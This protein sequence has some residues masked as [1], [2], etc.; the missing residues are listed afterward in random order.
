VTASEAVAAATTVTFQLKIDATG[1]TAQLADF[2]AGSFN[3]VT[4]T[5]PAGGTT[6][7]FDM[8]TITNDG[9]ELSEKYSVQA[10]VGSTVLTKQ[11]TILDGSVGAGQTFTLTTGVDTIPGLIGSNGNTVNS[12]ND[13]IIGVQSAGAT[14]TLTG[15]DFID[16]G[17]GVD[18]LRVISDVDG[19]AISLNAVSNAEIIEVRSASGGD[20]SIDTST[21]T[22]VTNLNITSATDTDSFTA[23]AADTTDIS[24]TGGATALTIKG[25]KNVTV[26]DATADKAITVSTAAAAG[27]AVGT[28]T[29]TDTKQGTGDIKVDGG[30]TVNVTAT[31]SSTDTDI[32]TGGDIIIGAFKPATGAVT[33]VQNLTST[34]VAV[35]SGAAVAVTGGSTVNVTVNATS[36]AKDDDSDDAITV[37]TVTV[38]GDGETT[39]VTAKQ[40]ATA[41][42]FTKPGTDEIVKTSVVTFGELKVGETVI[43]NG[44]TFTNNSDA[45]LTA[46]TVASIFANL[47]EDDLQAVG[48]T[49]AKGY[50]SN[51]FSTTDW[52]SGA[53]SGKTVT[54]T[55]DAFDTADLVL[56]GTAAAAATQVKSTNQADAVA[57]DKSTNAVAF[58]A[59]TV[60]E[61]DAAEAAITSVTLDGF[62]S[63]ALGVKAGGVT[64]KL[65]A[66]TTV[67][68]ANNTSDGEVNI[69]TKATALNLTV[70]D[71]IGGDG[72]VVNL[73]HN[74]NAT[75][76]GDKTVKTLTLNATG[77]ASAFELQARV[78]ETLTIDAAVALDLSAAGSDFDA[79]LVDVTVK[80]AGAVN[81][82]AIGTGTTLK[83]FNASANTGGVTATIDG[84]TANLDADFAEYVFSEGADV[85]A[86]ENVKVQEAIKLGGGNDKITLF[87]G[88]RLA[89]VT[90][91][92]DGGTGTN[93]LVLAADDA[94]ALSADDGFNGKIANFQ[95][96]S[97]G[98]AISQEVVDLANLD[99]ISYV[100][101]GTSDGTAQ[102]NTITVGGTIEVGDIFKITVN[103]TTY[104]FTAATTVINDVA[105]GLRAAITADGITV[106]GAAA[107]VTLTAANAGV[108]FTVAVETTE[109][110]GGAK[111]DQ[112]LVNVPTTPNAIGITLDNMATGGTVV[113][114]GAGEGVLVNVKDADDGA[115]DVLNVVVENVNGG[116]GTAAGALMVADVETINITANDGDNDVGI[117]DHS[118]VL[119]ADSVKTITVSSA[120]DIVLDA[121]DEELLDLTTFDLVVSG[122][123]GLTAVNA[124]AMIGSFTYTADDGVTTVTGGSGDDSLTGSGLNDVL[125]GGAG[126]DTLTGASK[127][128]LT[129]GA[130]V[131]TFKMTSGL[132]NINSYSIITDFLSGDVL[133][134][135]GTS[136]EASGVDLQPT[137]VFDSF[138][139]AAVADTDAGDVTWFQKD[140]NTYVV[141]NVSNGTSFDSSQDFIIQI[142]GLKDLSTASFNATNGTLEMA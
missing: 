49:T 137:A 57:D 1:D 11:V 77:K 132:A 109:A 96:V 38:T 9:T 28:I 44:L 104:S 111:D 53:A 125:L 68:L 94:E 70:N 4:V 82:G 101:L 19:T 99:G 129:G 56:G 98:N 23:T 102:L 135:T 107:A 17:E 54:F 66:L 136:F 87:T 76:D 127:T 69:A 60:L 32:T 15:V 118:L 67:S 10:T 48:G 20:G 119:V 72:A 64:N 80:G 12:G 140:G 131:D 85:V 55:A 42:T 36:T 115:A 41:T 33:V 110:G 30:S 78:V 105:A 46:E 18:T 92:I 124:S 43:V 122:T 126:N 7:T 86:M 3:P 123:T 26:T 58:G 35:V 133:D 116:G 21:K 47:T 103:G 63:A 112:T 89:D 22:G 100:T 14:A 37:G 71:I 6:A 24:V 25:G 51:A 2:N 13:T 113:L 52:T 134:T 79:K 90:A 50:Y 40:I 97:I 84:T 88:V 95:R 31:I 93:T 45:T 120:G 114:T 27:N 81:L 16:A 74:G 62:A 75:A 61:A 59:A 106:A 29:V 130:G 65:D 121:D 139:N 73:D 142:T 138:V 8:A 141:Q 108:P 34:G 39:T 117:D 5:I 83:T 128:T 91:N